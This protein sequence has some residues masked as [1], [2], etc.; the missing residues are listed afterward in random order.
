MK[1]FLHSGYLKLPMCIFAL[2]L[3]SLE[4]LSQEPP[5]TCAEKLQSAK[6]LF[7]R[8]Q[9]E[10]IPELINDCLDKGFNREESL[11]AYKL[12]IQV[13]LFNENLGRA[14]TAMLSFLRGNP[15]YQVS[16]TDHSGFVSLHNNFYS[17]IIIQTSL[18]IGL[19]MPFVFVIER[20]PLMGLSGD[21]SYSSNAANFFGAVE[22]KY[23]FNDR[24][25]LNAELG[26][27]QLSFTTT[28]IFTSGIPFSETNIRE[29]QR[30]IE[31][32]LTATYDIFRFGKL[33]PYA[34]MGIGPAL[35]MSTYAV[36]ENKPTDK[37][38]LIQR[39]GE[40]MKKELSR[41]FMDV[42]VQAGGG[43][44]YKTRGGFMFGEIRA[45][46]G[47]FDQSEFDG[48]NGEN[49]DRIFFYMSGDDRFRLNA[50]NFNAG[51]TFIFYKPVR[52]EE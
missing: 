44:K 39:S 36:G 16:P 51:Y 2:A 49:Q 47:L 48:Y 10:Q 8:G 1:T 17:K 4:A 34:R 9:V 37:N 38:N 14:D 6:S 28:E 25:E 15:E 3:V 21:K 32:P 11:E 7:D 30:R 52:R 5:P 24:I 45:N 35:N 33:T 22:A 46:F 50:L 23:R 19:N 26:Y 18:K 20:R 29:V 27:S 43:I 13:H 31:I 41:R 12:L 42:F 40:N